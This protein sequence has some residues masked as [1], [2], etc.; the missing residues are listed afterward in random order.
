MDLICA[1]CEEDTN[2]EFECPSCGAGPMHAHCLDDHACDEFEAGD[3][4]SD[5]F[6]E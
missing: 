3:E 5:E 1:W 6:D 4:D 2:D